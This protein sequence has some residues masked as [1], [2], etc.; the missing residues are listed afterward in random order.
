MNIKKRYKKTDLIKFAFKILKRV[1]LNNL[2]SKTVANLI[3]RA[4]LLYTSDAA[5][6]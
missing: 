4:C 1:G 3:V 2:N 5:D 6:E